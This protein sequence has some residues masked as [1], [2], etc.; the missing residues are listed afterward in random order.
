MKL[1]V[2][3]K[4]DKEKEDRSRLG[5]RSK[6]KG[7]NYERTVA[8]RFKEHY[9]VDLVRTPQSGGFAKK[10][11]RAEGFRG[12]IVPADKSVNLKLHIEC[13]NTKTWSLPSWLK[14]A[15]SD[16]PKDKIP[17]VVFHQHGTSNDYVCLSLND[18]LSL[19]PRDNAM[20]IAGDKK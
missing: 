20:K 12:D 8:R 1:K 17:L 7:S 15:E 3:K 19:V 13:K 2:A 14:Q 4:A 10:L 6:A 11:D 16:C 5:R 9:G 18:F